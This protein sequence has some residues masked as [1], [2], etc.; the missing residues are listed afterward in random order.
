M[1]KV[2][3]T[4]ADQAFDHFLSAYERKPDRIRNLHVYPN[5]HGMGSDLACHRFNQ[6]M[7]EAETANG[8]VELTW[9]PIPAKRYIERVTL[10]NAEALYAHLGRQQPDPSALSPAVLT[11]LAEAAPSSDEERAGWIAIAR[12]VEADWPQARLPALVAELTRI[13]AEPPDR[14]AFLA[15]AAGPLASSKLLDRLPQA[16]LR[17]IGLRLNAYPA[18]PV[19]LLTAGAARPEAVILVENPR[20]FERAFSITR[21]LPVAWISTHGLVATSVARA[22][23]GAWLGA[24][25]DGTPPPLDA[26]LA[27]P[28]LFYWGDLDQAGLMIFATARRRLPRI[29]LSALYRPMVDLLAKGGGHPYTEATDKA[30]QRSWHSDDPLLQSLLEACAISCVDQEWVAPGLIRDLCA[31]PYHPAGPV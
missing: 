19:V 17:R 6:R 9:K 3:V 12:A 1:A 7:E 13:R 24:P 11:V 26:L 15:S 4:S 16:A 10:R 14:P 29:A 27:T 8:A 2:E 21:D 31:L 22:L 18:P 5:Y 28:N 25:V 23:D 20:A 30:G